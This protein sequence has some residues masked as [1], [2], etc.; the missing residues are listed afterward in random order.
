MANRFYSNVNPD[1]GQE[2]E[3]KVAKGNVPHDNSDW[4]QTGSKEGKAEAKFKNTPNPN[5]DVKS[6]PQ[7][8]GVA[9]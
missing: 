5:E 4:A 9:E 1:Y 3:K 7:T 6:L 8:K 2:K